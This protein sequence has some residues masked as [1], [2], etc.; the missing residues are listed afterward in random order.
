MAGGNLGDLWFQ[1]GVK[2]NT[3]KELQ[4][5]IDKLKTG[6]DAANSLLRALQGFGTK[7]SGFKEQAEKAKEFADVLNEINR[8]ISKL[9]KNDKGDEAKDLQLA[10]K[11]ALSYLDMLQ[12]INIERSKI[13]ELRSLNPNVDTSKLR[14]AELM[15]E[16]INNQLFRLQNKAQGGGGGGVDSAN[17]LQDYAKVLQMTFRDVKQITDQFK[18]ENPLSAFS[19]G[20]AKVEADIARV[21]EKLARM[22]DLMA[23]GSLK[24]YSTNMLG[25]SI[26]ELDK[27]LARLQ[28]ASG[29]KSILTDA[30]QMKNLLSD[31]AVEM[32]KA[33]AATQAYGREKGKAIA[34][35][36][37]FA[38]A[39]KLSAKDNESE[40]KAQSDYI[41]RYKIGRAHV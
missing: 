2:D 6:D 38:A 14:E 40:L 8:R 35:E 28:A 10:V 34:V 26:T 32:T 13:S 19:G 15:L 3:S 12:R 27:I 4:K 20:A 33:T 7:K 41:K 31:V 30:A 18:K 23:E 5:I 25:G 9:K 11:N 36:M 21:T 24:G 17:V 39:A 1:L 22:R 29:N 16:N 37:E